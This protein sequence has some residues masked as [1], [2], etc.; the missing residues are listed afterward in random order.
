MKSYLG[1]VKQVVSD[2]LNYSFRNSTKVNP[3]FV[4]DLSITLSDRITKSIVKYGE[5]NFL[6]V[7]AEYKLYKQNKLIKRLTKQRDNL[8]NMLV[9][10]NNPKKKGICKIINGRFSYVLE[11]DGKRIPFNTGEEY[12]EQH[13]RKLGYE[14]QKSV[15]GEIL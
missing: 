8:L 3:Q 6:G 4:K 5:R 15:E 10:S 14:I 9:M 1:H 12:F 11:V 2:V 13:Y 7:I